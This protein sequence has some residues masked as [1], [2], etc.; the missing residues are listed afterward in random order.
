MRICFNH[1]HSIEVADRE[2]QQFGITDPSSVRP[3]LSEGE[4]REIQQRADAQ[5]DLRR[6]YSQRSLDAAVNASKTMGVKAAALLTG[7]KYWSIVQH[8]R[9]LKI[10]GLYKTNGKGGG[11]RKYTALQKRHCAV[12]AR[13]IMWQRKCSVKTAFQ[14]AGSRIGVNG[15]SILWMWNMGS[16]S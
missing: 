6:Q 4:L 16:I 14:A 9:V 3:H 2:L 13:Q 7:V 12:L 11:R 8:K 5:V 15:R 10:R 1:G